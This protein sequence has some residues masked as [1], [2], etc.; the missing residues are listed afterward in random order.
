ML[1]Y[2]QELNPIVSQALSVYPQ[3][4]LMKNNLFSAN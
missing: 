2:V 4:L 1:I 3:V